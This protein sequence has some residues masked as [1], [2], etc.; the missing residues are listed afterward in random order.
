MWVCIVA[1]LGIFAGSQVMISSSH[2]ISWHLMASSPARSSTS[3]SPGRSSAA[4]SAPRASSRTRRGGPRPSARAQYDAF[5]DDRRRLSGAPV[6][7]KRRPFQTDAV[8]TPRHAPQ[9]R[10]GRREAQGARAEDGARA[11]T[12]LRL[13]SLW[14]EGSVYV[15]LER[16]PYMQGFVRC[17]ASPR[18]RAVF[19]L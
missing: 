13:F 17:D 18:R 6:N 12:G 4:S 16:A 9:V 1:T 3:P 7:G 2:V 19:S 15:V 11:A 5:G 14:R 10:H 8:P